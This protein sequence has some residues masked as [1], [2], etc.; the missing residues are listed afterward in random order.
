MPQHT[1][2]T[3]RRAEDG[4][5]RVQG[6]RRVTGTGPVLAVAL[7][8]ALAACGPA[9]DANAPVPAAADAATPATVASAP[10]PAALAAVP[11]A[12]VPAAAPAPSLRV[13]VDDPRVGTEVGVR[14][15]G[16]GLGT[17]GK[18]GWLL[19]GGYSALPAGRYELA[20]QGFAQPGHAG[21]LYVDVAAGKGTQ[22]IAA[23]DVAP[24][25]LDAAALSGA[26]VL[27][28]FELDAARDDVEV[29]V[30]VT[31]ASKVSVS[32]FEIRP[33]P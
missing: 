25:A 5:R 22:I 28:P 26:L 18:P 6:A 17:S 10:A 4:L 15:P 19:F 31:A 27:L 13:A 11:P 29:R 30:R 16:M 8:I 9:P 21:L 32:G 2:R 1:T 12:V 23:A 7:A 24:D 14:T 3:E 20:V 33:R